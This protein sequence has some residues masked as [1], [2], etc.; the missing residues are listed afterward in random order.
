[1]RPLFLYLN[2]VDF[3]QPADTRHGVAGLP[4]ANEHISRYLDI[5]GAGV[6]Q[7]KRFGKLE[8]D[9]Q[10]AS[11]NGHLPTVLFCV[12]VAERK[13]ADRLSRLVKA[14]TSKLLVYIAS[15]AATEATRQDVF[16]SG[17]LC[18]WDSTLFPERDRLTTICK[19]DHFPYKVWGGLGT[20]LPAKSEV[21][22]ACNYAHDHRPRYEY[23][24]RKGL[25]LSGLRARFADDR[26][27]PHGG[28]GVNHQTV[29]QIQKADLVVAIMDQPY[30]CNAVYEVGIADAFH[31][32]S[33]VY[34]EQGAPQLPIDIRER[35][36]DY[37]NSP[38][39]LGYRL[40]HGLRETVER[41]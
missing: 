3:G 2:P 29:D 17:A 12:G 31:K 36:H 13:L 27:T 15:S 33:I 10:I 8:E 21:F 22:V 20:K 41:I 5:A 37:F 7:P 40:H 30:N 28:T 4:I 9:I 24:V 34:Q 23:W 38:E 35:V 6:R 1:M 11:Q 14:G 19:T 39:D 25:E 18:C 32:P 26:A 16:E